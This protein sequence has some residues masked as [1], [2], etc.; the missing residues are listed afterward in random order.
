[1]NIFYLDHDPV[2]AAQMQCN[3]HISKMCV[4]SAQMLSTAHRMLDGTI[5]L[6]PSKSGKRIVKHWILEGTN[7]DILYK[8]VH[9]NHPCTVWTRECSANYEWHFQHF[10]ALAE[11]YQF[12]YGKVHASLEKLYDILAKPPLHI[13]KSAE[14]TQI[15]LAMHDECKIS[16]DPVVCYRTFYMTKQDRFNMVWTKR[17]VPDWFVYNKKVA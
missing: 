2:I 12:R 16:D 9:I 11:E 5:V 1:M 7:N 13:R 3:K 8:A 6:G 14:L 15:P 10:V 4:E 17:N